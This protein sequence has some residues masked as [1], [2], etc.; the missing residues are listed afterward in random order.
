MRKGMDRGATEQKTT[1][2]N[3]KQTREKDGTEQDI[4]LDIYT[5]TESVIDI[6]SDMND[7]LTG[8]YPDM[9]KHHM[10]DETD[11]LIRQELNRTYL[12]MENI[13]E[14]YMREYERFEQHKIQSI[15]S[16]ALNYSCDSFKEY[17]N[18]SGKE[19]SKM[20]VPSDDIYTAFNQK[21]D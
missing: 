18:N 11:S 9:Q 1:F 4:L 15:I 19:A 16:E 8:L 3:E 14:V 2:R 10:D 17:L 20:N 21:N 5:K 7:R 13:I 6:L 12:E